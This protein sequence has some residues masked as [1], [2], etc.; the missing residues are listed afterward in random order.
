[1]GSVRAVVDLLINGTSRARARARGRTLG[2]SIYLSI[3]RFNIRIRTFVNYIFNV[4]LS[5]SLSL[6]QLSTLKNACNVFSLVGWCVVL[7]CVGGFSILFFFSLR[8]NIATIYHITIYHYADMIS[9][10]L[11]LFF[12]F[13]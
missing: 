11:S 4:P 7:C 9:L 1:M 12:F 3:W 13:G 5:L 6:S 10:P 2:A 8:G